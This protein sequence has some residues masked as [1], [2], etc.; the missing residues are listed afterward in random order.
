M[1]SFS[2]RNG[3]MS[4]PC[5]AVHAGA[6][7]IKLPCIEK[8]V[9]AIDMRFEDP[10]AYPPPYNTLNNGTKFAAPIPN[11][12]EFLIYHGFEIKDPELMLGN[13][14]L[15]QGYLPKKDKQLDKT[16]G[17]ISEK[18]YVLIPSNWFIHAQILDKDYNLI[19][20]ALADSNGAREKALKRN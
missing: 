12:S 17:A 9:G 2:M 14:A 7:G 20:P 1:A 18:G 6:H 16:P 19:K 4:I 8:L 10:Q 3:N 15:E 5:S 13:I 11:S